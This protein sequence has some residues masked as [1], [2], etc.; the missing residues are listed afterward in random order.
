MIHLTLIPYLAAA[1]ELK[2]KP[3][4]H[5]VKEL[6]NSGIQPDVI[7]CR[8]SKKISDNE[9]SKISLFCNVSKQSVIA[10]RCAKYI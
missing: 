4:Q 5:S 8:S 10:I 1:G 2:T 3:T 9:L 6:L 7:V